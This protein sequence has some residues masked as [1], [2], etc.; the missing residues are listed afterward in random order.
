MIS[1]DRTRVKIKDIVSSQLPGFVRET[2]PL[3]NDFFREYYS[4]QEY[5]GSTLDLLQNIDQY[6]DLDSLTNHTKTC[7]LNGDLDDFTTTI[8]VVYNPSQNLLGTYGFPERYGLI[9]IN[10]EIIL[11]KSKTET[12]FTECVRGFSGITKYGSGDNPEQLVFKE[13]NSEVHTDQSTIENLSVIFLE[14]FLRKIKDQ[15]LPGFEDRDISSKVNQK[16]LISKISDFYDS[17]GTEE[18]VR[19]LFGMLYGEDVKVVN[20][21]DFVLVPSSSTFRKTKDLVVEALEGDPFTLK[22]RTLYQDEIADYGIKRSEASVTDVE[23]LKTERG[24]YYR[25]KL[26]YNYDDPNN[27]NGGSFAPFTPH[28][29]T[30]VT[31]QVSAGSSVFDVDSTVGFPSSGNIIVS[32]ADRKSVV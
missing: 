22:N 3:L 32:L 18:S 4:S 8:N 11:Y 21:K 1:T 6:F 27:P 20:P 9:K 29:S 31:N 15:F 28:P 25:I 13:T 7:V 17:K 30:R 12:A 14:K 19:I 5:T 24:D 10:N 16:T 26:D 23:I 2:Y